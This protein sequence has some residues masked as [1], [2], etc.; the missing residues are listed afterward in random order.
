ME[1]TWHFEADHMATPVLLVAAACREQG[2]A[3]RSAGHTALSPQ[4]EAV[5]PRYAATHARATSARKTVGVTPSVLL[6]PPPELL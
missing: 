2:N 6:S 4:A 3:Q 1:T 5:L